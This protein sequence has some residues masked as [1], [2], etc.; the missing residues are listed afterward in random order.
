MNSPPLTA[1]VPAAEYKLFVRKGAPRLYWRNTNEGVY[2]S[3]KGI[4]WFL[5]GVSHTRDWNEIAAV[6]LFVAHV[7]KNGPIGTCKLTFKDGSVLSVISA[8][9]W[10]HSD[11]ERNVEY[12]RFL[13]DFHRVIP[14]S[15]REVIRFETGLGK[16]QYIGMTI[17]FVIA[18]VF[19]VVMPLGLTIYFRDWQALFLTFAGLGFIAPFYFMAK[20]GKPATYQPNQ[21]PPDFFP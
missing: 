4:G 2:L 9:K 21:V 10:G 6:N 18:A 12:G 20:R 7:P 16:G 3:P 13:T 8:S 11:D 15:E 19:F 1:E 5:D 17:A 14:D